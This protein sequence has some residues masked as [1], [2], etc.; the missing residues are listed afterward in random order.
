MPRI[1]TSMTVLLDA[2]ALGT[3]STFGLNV[4]KEKKCRVVITPHIKEFSR[5]I[6]KDVNDVLSDSVSLAKE[7][8]KEYGVI[9]V[10]KSAVT[11]ITDGEEL[12]IN[13]SGNSALAKAGSGDVLIG[14]T[15]GLMNRK[16]SLLKICASASFLMGRAAEELSI[17]QNEYTVTATEIISELPSVI[18]GLIY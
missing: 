13:S 12:F 9:V 7:F 15:I 4:L 14:I 11:I 17:K 1:G 3:I 16:E 5:L 10:L 18:N 6:N 8:A 2:D